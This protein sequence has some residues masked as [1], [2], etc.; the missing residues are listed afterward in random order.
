MNPR[1]KSILLRLLGPLPRPLQRL[2]VGLYRDR[3]AYLYDLMRR[4]GRF[5][6]YRRWVSLHDTI[7][8]ADRLAIRADIESFESRP[9]ISIVMPV[10]NPPARFLRAA[11]ISV[12]DQLYPH[13]ELCIADDASTLPH[14]AR[15]LAE[16]A[17]LDP[18]IRLLRR[19]RNG[20][21]SAASNSALALAT[22]EFVALLDHDD[23]LPVH[24]LY[25]VARE[26][27]RHPAADLIYSDEDKLDRRGRRFDPYFKSDWNPDLFLAQNMISH[28]GVYRTALVR[29]VGGFRSEFDGS[30]DY[31]LALRI[32]ERTDAERI[33]HI[34]HIL[35]HWR[36]ITGSAARSPAA[37]PHARLA[38]RKAV[39]AHLERRGIRAKVDFAPGPSFQEIRYPLTAEPFVTVIIPTRDHSDLLARCLA[40]LLDATDYR[41]FEVLIVDN[42][43]AEP[44]TAAL[45]RKIAADRRVRVLRYTQPFNFSLINNWA[46][47]QAGGEILLFLNN[48]TEVIRGD[49]LRHLVAN[50]V[51]PQVGAVGAKLLYPEGRVQ[52][53]GIILGMGGVAG[54]FH[55]RRRAEDP[56]YFGRALLQQNLSAVTAACLAMRRRIFEEVGGF[57]DTNL[58]VAFNDVDLCLRLRERGYLIVWTPLALLYHRESASRPFDLLPD[59]RQRF[60]REIAYMR[61]RWGTVLDR[62]PYFNPNLSLWDPTIA[63]A[64]PPRIS[65]SWRAAGSAAPAPMPHSREARGSASGAIGRV[66]H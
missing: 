6:A 25:L 31:D 61:R 55:L 48:D 47:Q 8:D 46:A 7:S 16:Y 10:F 53:G 39:A 11:L 54:H 66:R 30:Q 44:E 63:L 12:R 4:I 9:L 26:I 24:A 20:G 33:R 28:L 52:H 65:Y 14:V 23:V 17:A 3:F 40:G 19:P 64:F 35:Y 1:V 57:D 18:R 51:R 60:Q 37:K 62:D 13:W 49:W 22:G 45:Y 42:L 56:G 36:A 34:P 32:V 2:A 58:P 29:A 59:Q 15:I 27:I 21:I 41:N 5:D 50:A 43:S 38:A